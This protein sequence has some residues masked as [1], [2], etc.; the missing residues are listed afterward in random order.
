MIKQRLKLEGG[1]K[2]DVWEPMDLGGFIEIQGN[3]RVL[4][5]ANTEKHFGKCTHGLQQA[6]IIPDLSKGGENN[7]L[8]NLFAEYNQVN[9]AEAKHIEEAK[10][11][12]QAAMTGGR[13]LIADVKD[14]QTANE[15]FPLL[16]KLDHRLTSEREI[17]AEWVAKMKE[18]GLVY[19]K[20]TGQYV[21]GVKA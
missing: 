8:T 6:Y 14:A 5:L 11:L 1:F 17:K 12:Y 10:A 15:T 2:N 4:S 19:D 20:A 21:Q 3:N 9:Q 7:F 13:L 16:A 18:L